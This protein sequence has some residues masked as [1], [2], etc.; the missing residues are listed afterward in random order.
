MSTPACQERQR[1]S[2]HLCCTG[3]LCRKQ[4]LL[5]DRRLFCLDRLGREF[6]YRDEFE[7]PSWASGTYLLCKVDD[8]FT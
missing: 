7:D 1:E 2:A 5:V 3:A 8:I 4:V 6:L